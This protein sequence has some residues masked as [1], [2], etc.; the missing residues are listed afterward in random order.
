MIDA[1]NFM[2]AHNLLHPHRRIRGELIGF[3]AKAGGRPTQVK[4]MPPLA[5]KKVY[6]KYTDWK[7]ATD[8]DRKK[9]HLTY[10]EVVVRG[11]FAPE[12]TKFSTFL[13]SLL[14]PDGS[15]WKQIAEAKIQHILKGDKEPDIPA[16][17]TSDDGAISPLRDGSIDREEANGSHTDD[18]SS[19]QQGAEEDENEVGMGGS[20]SGSNESG[21]TDDADATTK[22]DL[23]SH[24]RSMK[25]MYD[26]APN[27]EEKI[28]QITNDGILGTKE[29]TE[30]VKEM[31]KLIS[32][33]P[34]H[35]TKIKKNFSKAMKGIENGFKTVK[36]SHDDSIEQLEKNADWK[37]KTINALET[38]R[39]ATEKDSQA[40]FNTNTPQVKRKRNTRSGGT[41]STKKQRKGSP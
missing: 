8:E 6:A 20:E 23:M 25:S 21:H 5:R 18:H 33:L 35:Y 36:N 13:T 32:E 29:I 3:V 12:F 11:K 31:K 7:N 16:D 38:Y 19:D 17:P 22:N 10:D 14:S 34:G 37:E 26:S 27:E 39:L 9:H 2:W 41:S 4:D 24:I 28:E 15:Q 30:S 40:N 1:N